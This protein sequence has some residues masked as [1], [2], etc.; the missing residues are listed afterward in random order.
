MME[1]YDR[2]N[3]IIVMS[4]FMAVLLIGCYFGIKADRKKAENQIK[5]R[6]ASRI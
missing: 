6:G 2:M 3:D 5:P 1:G 4:G